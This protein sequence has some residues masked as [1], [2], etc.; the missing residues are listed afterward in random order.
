MVASPE[1]CRMNGAKSKGAVTERGKAI[2]SRNATKHG[3][4]AEKPPILV[5]EDL[6]TFQGLMQNLVD[7]YQPT[8]A[9]EWHLVQTIAMC[10]QRQNRLWVAEAAI[11]NAQLLP[12]VAK[13]S[14]DETYPLLKPTEQDERWSVFHPH[15]LRRERKLL[16]WFIERNQR[17]HF[18]TERRSRYF[19]DIWK[20]WIEST[21]QDLNQF[22]N[23]YPTDGIPGK[24]GDT[25]ALIDQEQFSSRYLSWLRD[26]CKMQHPFAECWFY[27]I[28]LK[29]AAPP[30]TKGLWDYYAQTHTTILETCQKRI[31]Q[32][33]Q[34]EQKI[35][36]ERDRY[37]SELIARQA[38]TASPIPQSIALLS[39]YESHIAKQL[40]QAIRQL[41][42]LQKER[43]H[44][45]S[46]GSFG[47][48]SDRHAAS[49]TASFTS[50]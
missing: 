33:E 29:N 1:V 49:A 23:E 30:K 4:L 35:Q 12:P 5:S 27:G 15:N 42:N 24:P 25:L 40:E 41:Q 2:A 20:D 44:G 16:T 48:N 6:E 21:L 18:P 36:Q 13:P 7:Q 3:L 14:T 46:M 31:E 9:V 34:I 43:Q 19:A 45:G 11:G 32:I 10:I 28:T 26:L 38:L 47:Q 17:E 39:R 8:G 22:K 37:Q 50:Q